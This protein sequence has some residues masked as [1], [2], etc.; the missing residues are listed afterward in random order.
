VAT[1]K[2]TP[3]FTTVMTLEIAGETIVGACGLVTKLPTSAVSTCDAALQHRSGLE[4]VW[5]AQEV[6]Q[7]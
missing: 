5:C 7:H 1:R 4:L 2:V 6:L 3:E